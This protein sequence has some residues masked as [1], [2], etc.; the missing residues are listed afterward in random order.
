MRRDNQLLKMTKLTAGWI[1]Q[2]ALLL[3]AI[4]GEFSRNV[5]SGTNTE[6]VGL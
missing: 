3:L 4:N 6:S 2:S 1:F 5:T